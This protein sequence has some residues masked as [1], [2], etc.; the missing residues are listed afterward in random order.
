MS[1][2]IVI[3]SLN[4]DFES[5]KKINKNGIEYW[6]ARELMPILGYKKW[7]KSEEVVGRAARACVG[8]LWITIFTE[9]GKWSKSAQT[10]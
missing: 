8:R 9:W 3:N 2:E 4:K 1:N 6:E 10:P 5:I 7:E